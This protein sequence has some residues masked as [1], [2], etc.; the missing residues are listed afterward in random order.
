MR[1]MRLGRFWIRTV[2]QKNELMKSEKR[3][4]DL[5]GL[6]DE[7]LQKHTETEISGC[8]LIPRKYLQKLYSE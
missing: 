7:W 4:A 5:E 8:F 6:Y 1:A 2:R 3:L